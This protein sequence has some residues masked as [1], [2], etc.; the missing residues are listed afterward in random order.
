MPISENYKYC[1]SAARI[2]LGI[3][4][5]VFVVLQWLDREVLFLRFFL[6]NSDFE[7]NFLF[8][9]LL[10]LSILFTLGIYRKIAS[11]LILIF[12]ILILQK[13]LF[14][15][16]IHFGYIG[17][18]LVFFALA[19]IS[20][21]LTI[22]NPTSSDWKMP[23][24]FFHA[25][26]FCLGASYTASGLAKHSFSG[27]N[28]GEAVKFYFHSGACKPY[29]RQI[30]ENFSQVHFVFIA[31]FVGLLELVALPAILIKKTRPYIWL[32]L[33]AGQVQMLF[34]SNIFNI[35]TIL[36]IL[37]ILCFDPSWLR[38]VTNDFFL[39]KKTKDPPVKKC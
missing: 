25:C 28:S 36:I 39:T 15:Y 5:I 35:S 11:V 6:N 26:L 21:P 10:M 8:S 37:H 3:Y 2:L 9:V 23:S 24:V 30:S 13:N 22:S 20:E 18:M 1:I 17:W 19:P 16:E 29:I 34:T 33:T 38:T 27:W 7:I 14:L 32:I 4:L 31:Y 12:I